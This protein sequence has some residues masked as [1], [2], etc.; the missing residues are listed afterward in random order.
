MIDRLKQIKADRRYDIPRG[1]CDHTHDY[2][3]VQN[4]DLWW[5][6]EEVERLRDNWVQA[7][8]AKDAAELREFRANGV[9]GMK[10]NA[11]ESLSDAAN[12]WYGEFDRVRSEQHTEIKRLRAIEVAA[13][14]RLR[15]LFARYRDSF[16]E[17]DRQELALFLEMPDIGAERDAPAVT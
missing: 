16:S 11:G 15:A 13:L 1:A 5:L 10:M 3:S 7:G 14:G 6:I 2:T 8:A 12:R 17:P 4:R 9:F